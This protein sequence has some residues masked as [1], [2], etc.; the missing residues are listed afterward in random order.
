MSQPSEVMDITTGEDD[1]GD[2]G[3]FIKA[4]ESEEVATDVSALPTEAETESVSSEAF[5]GF[6]GIMFTVAEQATSIIAGVDFSFDD[7]GKAEV[8]SAALPVLSKH[9]STLMQV[10]GDYIEE[11]TLLI[12]VLA[13]VYTSKRHLTQLKSAKAEQE[14]RDAEKQ[15]AATQP[16]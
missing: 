1:W 8:I 6:L 4:L 15:K 2:F 12:A 14:K 13:L 3:G 16:A 7:K 10:F 5:E 9:G 11:A